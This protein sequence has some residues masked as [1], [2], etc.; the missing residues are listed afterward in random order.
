MR[1]II[2]TPFIFVVLFLAGTG[3]VF[4]QDQDAAVNL[5]DPIVITDEFA[6][7]G[8]EMGNFSGTTKLIKAETID[9]E[10]R[11]FDDLYFEGVLTEVCQSRGCNFYIDDGENQVRVRFFDYG[12]FIPTDSNG[13][14]TV[15]RGDFVQKEDEETG[16]SFVEILSTAIKIYN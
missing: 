15:V 10:N 2:I 1:E 13:K 7:Y 3:A 9:F 4:A 16:E 8:G 6:V 11:E 12:F 5:S 14:K